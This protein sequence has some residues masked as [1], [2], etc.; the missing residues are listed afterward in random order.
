M[1]HCSKCRNKGM[2]PVAQNKAGEQ[3]T[4]CECEWGKKKRDEI[5]S[6]HISYN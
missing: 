1:K 2:Y 3:L 4:F 5:L 6:E